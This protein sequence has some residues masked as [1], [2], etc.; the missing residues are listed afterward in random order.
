M[1]NEMNIVNIAVLGS[2]KGTVLQ[3]VIDQIESGVL[4]GINIKFVLSNVEKAGILDKARKH[5]LK[6]I[7]LTGKD[8]TREEYDIQVSQLLEN[9]KIDL[10]LLIGYMRLMSDSF[11][12]KWL[13]KVVN[14]HPSILPA[15]A[16]Q[17]DLNVHQAVIDR[18]CKLTGASLIFIDE[19]ADTGPIISQKCIMVEQDDTAETLKIKV[20]RLEGEMLVDFLYKWYENKIKVI[21]NKVFI[22][23]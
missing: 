7:Y 17:M 14:I 11:V 10:V 1:S 23:N 8:K 6:A 20:Q 16:G 12:K 2:T 4:K 21:N 5:N 15:F 22:V 9:D 3:Y 19:N 18:G 13:N